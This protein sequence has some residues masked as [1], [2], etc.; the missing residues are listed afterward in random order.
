M[1]VEKYQVLE[2]ILTYKLSQDHL[3]LFFG[4]I[5]ARDGLNNNSTAKQFESAYR[6]LLVHSQTKGPNTGNAQ[7]LCDI[8]KYTW[9][10]FW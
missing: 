7:N 10:V 3:E 1:L 6:R 9:R 8:H 5:R 4:A 2:Y